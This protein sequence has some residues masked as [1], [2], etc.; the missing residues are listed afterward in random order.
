M[1]WGFFGVSCAFN[2][3]VNPG[4]WINGEICV[5]LY[6]TL[7]NVKPDSFTLYASRHQWGDEKSLLLALQT[8]PVPWASDTDVGVARLIHSGLEHSGMRLNQTRRIIEAL[9]KAASNRRLKPPTHLC[10][11]HWDSRKVRDKH[12]ECV[13]PRWSIATTYGPILNICSQPTNPRRES[14]PTRAIIIIPITALI[15]WPEVM[16]PSI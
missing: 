4:K 3:N 12:R 5:S 15:L 6:Q 8:W 2:K 16:N 10:F 7:W 11:K 9:S 13:E 1:H 14:K